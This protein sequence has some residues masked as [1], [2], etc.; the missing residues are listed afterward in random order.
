MQADPF[1][2]VREFEH[3]LCAYT[4]AHYA[5]AVNSCTMALLL[6][7]AWFREFRPEH[8]VDTIS[9]PKLTYVGVPQS[10]IHAGFGVEWRDEDWQGE[11][12]LD[13]FPVWDSARRFTVG[14]FNMKTTFEH[15]GHVTKKHVHRFESTTRFQ[16]VSFHV[17]KIL[18]HSQGGAILHNHPEADGWLRRARFDGRTEG[19][20]A[21]QDS[22]NMLGWH[23]YM[24]PDV[25]AQLRFKLSVLPNHNPDL[26]RSNYPDLSRF[27]VFLGKTASAR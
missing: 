25:A 9:L 22:F 13:P 17:S 15:D 8:G 4:G 24:S 5:V 3:E 21:D 23:C 6:A 27:P 11:Y 7:C 16:C 10:V 14:M 12:R 1:Q 26:P 2:S 19:V 20:P 18:G